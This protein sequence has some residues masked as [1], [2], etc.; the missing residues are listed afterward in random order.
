[1]I[2]WTKLVTGKLCRLLI[3]DTCQSF[4]ALGRHVPPVIITASHLD[5]LLIVKYRL[6]FSRIQPYLSV[7]FFCLF[8]VSFPCE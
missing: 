3:S 5:L 4:G 8:V 2:H 1:M 7:F 6:S